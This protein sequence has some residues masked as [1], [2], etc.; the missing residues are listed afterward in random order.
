MREVEISTAMME[1]ARIKAKELGS[2]RN[3]ITRGGGNIIG[4][5]GEEVAKHCLGGE[6]ENTYDYDLVMKDGT[7][8]DV[9]TVATTVAPKDHYN[10]V[11]AAANTKQKCDAYSFVR[12]KKDLSVG[13]YLGTM[14]KSDFFDIADKHTKGDVDQYGFKMKADCYVTQISTLQDNL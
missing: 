11:V 10:C 13:W 12:V 9:K 8:I 7:K 1:N 2:L 4:F 3:S 14:K 6:L 5:L